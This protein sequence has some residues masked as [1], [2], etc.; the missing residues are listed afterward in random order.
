MT[1]GRNG[2]QLFTSVRRCQFSTGG[3]LLKDS[4][5]NKEFLFAKDFLSESSV[6]QPRR[7]GDGNEDL[8]VPEYGDSSVANRAAVLDRVEISAQVRK[9]MRSVPQPVS[10]VT[11]TDI[12][13]GKPVFRGATI[14]SFN[15]VTIK[16]TTIVSLNI[17]RPSSTFDAIESSGFFL[18]HLLNADQTNS[19]LAQVFTKGNSYNPF[20][21]LQD[22]SQIRDTTVS[23]Q[24]ATA[25]AG[26]PLINCTSPGHLV[27]RYLSQKTVEVGDH[28]II[29]G[30]VDKVTKKQ[31]LLEE[32][33]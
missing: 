3:A 20:Q 12:S 2:V 11:S 7:E 4:E 9:A 30:I 13:T 28:V 21:T 14:S 23:G 18:I 24:I 6:V 29:F 17:K 5:A 32:A 19:Q 31:G 26:P 16:P 22:V 10:I 25:N 8:F 1:T 15:T 33:D 27:C